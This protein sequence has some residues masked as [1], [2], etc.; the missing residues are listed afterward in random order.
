M[1]LLTALLKALILL[2]RRLISPWLPPACRFHPT[3][4]AYALEAVDRF[5]PFR[6]TWLALQRI[7]RC[8]PFH[9]GGYDPVPDLW[10]TL[11]RSDLRRWVSPPAP[12]GEKPE[13][14]SDL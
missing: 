13:G 10:P 2:Y 12:P 4:S 1:L 6:G 8:H 9:P 3:C 7:G 5:G 11:G 14:P